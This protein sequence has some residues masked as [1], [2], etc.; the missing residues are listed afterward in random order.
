[1]RTVST[2]ATIIHSLY[3]LEFGGK[4]DNKYIIPRQ[5]F[6]DKVLQSAVIHPEMI[7]KINDEL[8]MTEPQLRVIN[9]DS[10]FHVA[11]VAHLEK[12]RQVPKVLLDEAHSAITG[13]EDDR[14]TPKQIIMS[15]FN[16]E[17]GRK[18]SGWFRIYR[19]DLVRALGVNH[20]SELL[21][22]ELQDELKVGKSGDVHTDIWLLDLG[23]FFIVIKNK[24][25]LRVR[26]VTEGLLD[27][28]LKI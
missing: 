6:L 24:T 17:Y 26:K 14:P 20:L 4:K 22:R 28:Q 10:Y 9:L 3:D 15:F 5:L 12:I 8:A 16:A 21:I 2:I 23:H 19:H 1:M 11:V 25:L 27:R 18:M 7:T 13:D